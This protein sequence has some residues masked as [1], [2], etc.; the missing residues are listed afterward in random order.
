MAFVVL[1]GVSGLPRSW[2]WQVLLVGPVASLW[3]GGCPGVAEVARRLHVRE[4]VDDGGDLLWLE[5]VVSDQVGSAAGDP[6]RDR[7]RSAAGR[8]NDATSY[9]PLG[10]GLAVRVGV[11][12]GGGDAALQR[13][14]ISSGP[15]P[16][17]SFS[18]GDFGCGTPASFVSKKPSLV[19][20]LS[21]FG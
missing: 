17:R 2:P 10:V 4:V 5:A 9:A 19:F 18:V 14:P 16:W 6:V 15:R 11:V 20:G 8:E 7:L 1:G 13:S 12:D 3:R 21:F